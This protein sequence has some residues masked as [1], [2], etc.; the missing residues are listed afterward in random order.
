MSALHEQIYNEISKLVDVKELKKQNFYKKFKSEGFMDLNIETLRAEKD[1]I[2]IAISHYYEQN[3]DLMADPDME[4]RVYTNKDWKMAEALT[5][6][7]D[8]LGVYQQV[9]KEMH[10]KRLVNQGLKLSLNRFLLNWLRR[11]Q[12]QGYEEVEN[13]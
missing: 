10:G 7:Q 6:Q 8:S 3:G 5:Y 13:E 11:I 4:V 2:V 12:I 1:S 9:Y